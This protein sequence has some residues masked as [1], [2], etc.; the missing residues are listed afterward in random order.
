M[1]ALTLAE[2]AE[3]V[4]GRLDAADPDAR[5][6]GSVEFDSRKIGQGDLFVALPGERVDGH[7]FAPAAIAAGAV[8]ALIH[9]STPVHMKSS[10][11]VQL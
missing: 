3:A 4:G 2:V 8:A 10:S 11:Y 7:D 9:N 5:V 6:T 1:I